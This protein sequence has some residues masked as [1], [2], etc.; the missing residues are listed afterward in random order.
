MNT[1]KVGI[2]GFGIVGKRRYKCLRKLKNV[3]V[4]AVCDRN[5]FENYGLKK[6]IKFYSNY[7]YLFYHKQYPQTL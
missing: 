7:K 2:A 5:N 4:V 6:N 1:L 3:E